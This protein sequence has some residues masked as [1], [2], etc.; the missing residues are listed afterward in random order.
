MILDWIHD[1]GRE[2]ARLRRLETEPGLRGAMNR[3]WDGLNG[4]IIIFLIGNPLIGLTLGCITGLVAT[5]IVVSSE[6]LSDLRDGYCTEGFYLNRKF[7][8]LMEDS[9][10]EWV[11]WGSSSAL[12]TGIH[13]LCY[14]GW[15]LL[16]AVTSAYLVQVYA[17]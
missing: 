11:S 12:F 8:C 7:C 1:L 6:W 3:L 5:F 16:F 15:S 9:C 2:R 10:S 17:P 14:V 4:W 13:F